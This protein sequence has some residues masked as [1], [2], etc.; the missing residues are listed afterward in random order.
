MVGL[1]LDEE[2]AREQVA[3]D[4]H[5]RKVMQ[6]IDRLGVLLEKSRPSDPTPPS[7]NNFL[8]DNH[9]DF[10]QD[11]VRTVQRVVE[12]PELVDTYVLTSYIQ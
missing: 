9:L 6:F 5:Q 11:S 7:T 3:F 8:V 10:L 4:E 1:E 2:T 12:T